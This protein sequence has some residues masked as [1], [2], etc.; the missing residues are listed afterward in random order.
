MGARRS[1][2]AVHAGA[3]TPSGCRGHASL[4]ATNR[5]LAPRSIW[6]S[7]LAASLVLKRG[8]IRADARNVSPHRFDE[9]A[10]GPPGASAEYRVVTDELTI[11]ELEVLQLVAD[12]LGNR[13]IARA[14]FVSEETV[15]THVRRLLRKLKATSRAHAVAIALR[16]RLIY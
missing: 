15:K 4:R 8:C 14:L 9:P 10:A 5:I 2:C 16:K 12:G 1:P 6:A 7:R 11:R 3:R 13:Q